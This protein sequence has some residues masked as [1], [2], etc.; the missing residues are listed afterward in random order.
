MENIQEKLNSI[1]K[2]VQQ[3]NFQLC[4]KYDEGKSKGNWINHLVLT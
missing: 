4:S 1:W 3:Y 2:E